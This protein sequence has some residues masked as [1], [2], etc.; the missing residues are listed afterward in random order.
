MV[1]SSENYFVSHVSSAPSVP[2]A[3]QKAMAMATKPEKDRQQLVPSGGD[4]GFRV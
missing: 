1:V 2:G 4:Q 3:L